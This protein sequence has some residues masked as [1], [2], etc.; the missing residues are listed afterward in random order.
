MVSKEISRRQSRRS[1]DKKCQNKFA[2]LEEVK[3]VSAECGLVKESQNYDRNY[4]A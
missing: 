3:R 4:A 2:L 1:V